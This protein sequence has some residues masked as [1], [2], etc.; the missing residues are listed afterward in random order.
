MVA[1]KGV[2]SMLGMLGIPPAPASVGSD[3]FKGGRSKDWREGGVLRK[4]SVR[5]LDIYQRGTVSVR[6]KTGPGGE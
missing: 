1:R 2:E 6:W 4:T 3:M 5:V